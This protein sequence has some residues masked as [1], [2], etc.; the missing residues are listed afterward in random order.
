MV[1]NERDRIPHSASINICLEAHG[2]QSSMTT[3]R[4]PDYANLG[5]SKHSKAL[6]GSSQPEASGK[7]ST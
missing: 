1:A 3:V 4:Q 5:N 7:P 6:Y 2:R